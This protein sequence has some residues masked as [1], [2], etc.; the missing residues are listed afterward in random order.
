MVVVVNFVYVFA[1]NYFFDSLFNVSSYH[2]CYVVYFF[3]VSDLSTNFFAFN[4]GLD[5]NVYHYDF[6]FSYHD[7]GYPIFFICYKLVV[8]FDF[9]Y[10]SFFIYC[11]E[12]LL[13][14]FNYCADYV[15]FF[16]SFSVV[17]LSYD[18]I[19]FVMFYNYYVYHEFFIYLDFV[20]HN[21]VSSHM[22]GYTSFL[23]D[24]IYQTEFFDY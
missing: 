5:Y 3:F 20:Y 24:D 15:G 12:F 9:V 19:V 17:Y 8:E 11:F 6:P 14:R 4:F 13:I 2:C 7:F 10:D 16:F 22:L 23:A 18:L 1:D 21:D